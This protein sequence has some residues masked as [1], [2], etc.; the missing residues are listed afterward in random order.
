[1]EN[2]AIHRTALRSAPKPQRAKLFT[3]AVSTTAFLSLLVVLL[4]NLIGR[5]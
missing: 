2:Q 3:S 5:M 1:M 4:V